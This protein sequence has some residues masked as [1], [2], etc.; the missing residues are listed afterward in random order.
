M[1]LCHVNKPFT[2]AT[3]VLS[4][5]NL[6]SGLHLMFFV[7]ILKLAQDVL[8]FFVVVSNAII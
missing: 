1:Q 6:P 2:I 8:S 7:I 5:S 3:D 4:T